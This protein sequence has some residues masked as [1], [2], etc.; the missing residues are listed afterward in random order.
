MYYLDVW[1][2]D[3]YNGTALGE[4]SEAFDKQIRDEDQAIGEGSFRINRHSSQAAWCVSRA[5]VRVRRV[6]GGPFAYDD[7]RYVF[8]FFIEDSSDIALSTDEEGGEDLTRG[9]RGL[10]S[11]LQRAIIYPNENISGHASYWADVPTTGEV[12]FPDKTIGEAFRILILNAQERDGVSGSPGALAFLTIDFTISNDSSGA[13]WADTED[14]WKFPVGMNL[15]DV[16][17]KLVA[18]QM[19]LR[20]TPALLLSCYDAHPGDDLSG[21]V[22]FAKGV[23]LIEAAEKVVEA[24]GLIT[25]ALVKGTRKDNRIV[26]HQSFT[27]PDTNP[28][29]TTYGRIEGYAEYNATPF[30]SRLEKVGRQAI[31]RSRLQSNGPTTAGVLE[32]PG[33]V[34]WSD[35]VAGDSV[36]LDIPGVYD[37]DVVQVNAI[38]M[39][40]DEA[41][42]DRIALEFEDSPFDQLAGPAGFGSTT[43]TG[44]GSGCNDCP[45]TPPFVPDTGGTSPLYAIL[46]GPTN[47]PDRAFYPRVAWRGDGD[48]PPTGYA[49]APKTGGVAYVDATANGVTRRWALRVTADATVDIHAVA[50]MAEVFRPGS[51]TTTFRL[52]VNN[53][54]LHAQTTGESYPDLAYF[55]DSYDHTASGVTLHA[56]DVVSLEAF[57]SYGGVPVLVPAGTDGGFL[58][59]DGTGGAAVAS[60][61]PQQGQMV[62]EEVI[63]TAG[64]TTYASNYPY[65]PNGLHVFAGGARITVTQTDPTAGTFALPVELPAGTRLY[66]WYQAA[67]GTYLGTGNNPSPSPSVG[68]IPYPALGTGGDGSGDHVLHDDGTWQTAT[69]GSG[70]GSGT[71]DTPI[72][73]ATLRTEVLTGG[74]TPG[75]VQAVSVYE[76]LAATITADSGDGWVAPEA[77]HYLVAWHNARSGTANTFNT[78]TGWTAHPN[79]TVDSGFDRA[80]MYYKVADGT[81]TAV[82]FALSGGTQHALTVIE[83]DGALTLDASA[84]ATGTGA[85]FGTGSVTPTGGVPGI[86]VGGLT[87]RLSDTNYTTTPGAGWT[88]IVDSMIDNCVGGC[89]TPLHWVGYQAVASTSGAYN[90]SGTVSGSASSWGGQTLAFVDTGTAVWIDAPEASDADDATYDQANLIEDSAFLRSDL[91]AAYRISRGR[92]LVGYSASG[93]KTVELWGANEE[94]FSDEVELDSATFTAGSSYAT[95]D[96]PFLWIDDA[97]YRYFRVKGAAEARR[98]FSF[99]L[100]ETDPSTLVVIDPATGEAAELQDALDDIYGAIPTTTWEYLV[101]GNGWVLLDGVGGILR[102]QVAEYT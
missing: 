36:T 101:D 72:D 73:R 13:A 45:D 23:D 14:I 48:A 28:L 2:P 5:L 32:L 89:F 42:N 46:Y 49:S 7:P 100:Y 83:L 58:E 65:E 75:I 69:T 8:G 97:A 63:V 51:W 96:I 43:G 88:E 86:I 82:T 35:Y 79:G 87:W 18:A 53:A 21:S 16:A 81:E 50:T 92:L 76:A 85:S 29:E 40:E 94:D 9:G 80:A 74:G 102:Q 34:A 60:N 19:Y 59:L 68:L 33:K 66:L 6:A 38:I 44:G 1:A 12:T 30:T 55:T 99:E 20:I 67:S 26:Y 31:H 25:R 61:A 70:S 11:Y 52:L 84:E 41:G 90:P 15:L 64:D 24:Q 95:S 78:P 3:D 77:G 37:T 56:G 93:S 62:G 98:V 91:G 10:L 22:T 57:W 47:S 54:V 71:D 39:T 4:L 17:S 27:G